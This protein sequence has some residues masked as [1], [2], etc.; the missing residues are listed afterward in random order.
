MLRAQLEP[1]LV[2]VIPNALVAEQFRPDPSG[3]DPEHSE[4]MWIPPKARSG[5]E[6]VN[7]RRRHLI[8]CSHHRSDLPSGVSKGNRLARRLCPEDMRAVPVGTVR[9]GW[10]RT[11]DGRAG[12][13][14]GEVS[15]PRPDRAAWLDTPL[16]R[17]RGGS[18]EAKRGEARRS[19]NPQSWPS[20]IVSDRLSDLLRWWMYRTVNLG[21]HDRYSHEA[22]STSTPR[23]PRHSAY[24]SSKPPLRVSSWS[25]P[26]LAG[27][28][29]SSRGT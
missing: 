26:A 23:S 2:S 3:A 10:R 9:C 20:P 17:A 28:P 12:A 8:P 14:A 13:D 18:I 25:A 19:R 4:W 15:P 27:C 6:C 1:G 5:T 7:V 29:R 11:Q 21:S 16:G 24:P 22:K